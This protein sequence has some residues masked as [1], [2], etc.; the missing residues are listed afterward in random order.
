MSTRVTGWASQGCF[1]HLSIIPDNEICTAYNFLQASVKIPSRKDEKLTRLFLAA[2]KEGLI[3]SIM[4]EHPNPAHH[5]SKLVHLSNAFKS[6]NAST[7]AVNIYNKDTCCEFHHFLVA[8]LAAYIKSL[9]ALR[10]KQD[11]SHGNS[12]YN[13]AMTLWS[14]GRSNILRVHLDLLEAAS[15]TF[16]LVPNDH[17]KNTYSDNFPKAPAGGGTQAERVTEKEGDEQCRDRKR[18]GGEEDA[19]TAAE[20]VEDGHGEEESEDEDG[21]ED[22]D[23][24]EDG[25]YGDGDDSGCGDGGDGDG[26]ACRAEGCKGGGKGKG[27]CDNRGNGLTRRYQRWIIGL[28]A[29]VDGL[30]VLAKSY[31]AAGI[32]DIE[33]QLLG[34]QPTPLPRAMNDWQATIRTLI[35]APQAAPS[36]L[37]APVSRRLFIRDLADQVI[38]ILTQVQSQTG[39]SP[40]SIVNNF[41]QGFK[42]RG[43]VHCEMI[44]AALMKY[45][46]LSKCAGCLSFCNVRFHFHL[47]SVVCGLTVYYTAYYD[48]RIETIL[49]HVFNLVGYF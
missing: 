10:Q 29:Q 27:T 21:D 4:A 11:R 22:V 30:D 15:I 34:V 3:K 31:A 25:V 45:F 43:K 39:K 44:I 14:V 42:F 46:G 6:A 19:S 8:L 7:I 2:E 37:G 18:D 26:S 47:Y 12:F 28:V 13:L 35:E 32:K 24:D 23:V 33:V 40:D 16:L 17:N 1:Y 41:I 9:Q 49:S 38:E 5:A 48:R 36:G 20:V